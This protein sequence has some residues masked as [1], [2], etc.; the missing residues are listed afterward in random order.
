MSEGYL[1]L[2][3]HPSEV[4]YYK[5]K[6]EKAEAERDLMRKDYDRIRERL[7]EETVKCTEAEN[8]LHQAMKWIEQRDG[9]AAVK[10]IKTT[11]P[12]VNWIERAR[13]EFS[14]DTSLK[15]GAWDLKK[16]KKG[17]K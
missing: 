14:K 3:D 17:R 7:E 4:E 6:F 15:R 1:E 12:S 16:V 11:S 10:V 13:D 9:V 5:Q 2:E 8:K